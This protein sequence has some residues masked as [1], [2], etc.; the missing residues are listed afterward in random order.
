M[1][2]T[3]CAFVVGC[4]EKEQTI[5]SESIP[6]VTPSPDPNRMVPYY[7]K[8]EQFSGGKGTKEEPYLIENAG[9]LALLA[10]IFSEDGKD[11]YWDYK[12]AYFKQIDDIVV[13]DLTDIENWNTKAPAYNWLPIGSYNVFDGYYDGNGYQISGVYI[14]EVSSSLL[15]ASGLFGRISNASI[16]DVNLNNSYVYSNTG[17]G[18]IV[19]DAQNSTINNCIFEG[20]I[21]GMSCAGGIAGHFSGQAN[22]CSNLGCIVSMDKTISYVGGIFGKVSTGVNGT[23]IEECRNDGEII[24]VGYCSQG[25]IAGQLSVNKA[26]ELNDNKWNYYLANIIIQNCENNGSI[27]GVDSN[28][29]AST[30]GIVGHLYSTESADM[31]EGCTISN[32]SNKGIIKGTGYVGGILGSS[33]MFH[34]PLVLSDSINASHVYSANYAGGIMG[35][36]EANTEIKTI[37]YCTNNGEVESAAY[38]GGI[39]GAYFGFNLDVN[40]DGETYITKCQNLGN[41]K[42][43]DLGGI[44]GAGLDVMQT[45]YIDSCI[46]EGT[47]SGDINTRSGGI[48]GQDTLASLVKMDNCTFKLTNCVNVG[49][50]IQGN[51]KLSF[52]KNVKFLEINDET[53]EEKF[54]A[55]DSSVLWSSCIGGI[56][57]SVNQS[58]VENCV[59]IGML[60]ADSNVEFI[61][62]HADVKKVKKEGYIKQPLFAGG[63]C[64]QYLFMES[65]TLDSTGIYNCAYDKTA[66]IAYSNFGFWAG[67]NSV[68]NI[69]AM[70]NTSAKKHAEELMNWRK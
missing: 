55:D 3:I 14:Y 29:D 24:G 57:G 65:D 9:H 35:Y 67:E 33:S 36:C 28:K 56:V 43:K 12:G 22:N 37:S 39:L 10:Y 30:G 26:F 47:I 6:I 53:H 40:E 58:I 52:D 50:I 27:I 7:P 59:N 16:I 38:G 60:L 44:V 31:C 23:L 13:N 11:L 45:V 25:G 64:G 21:Y 2:A 46:N 42:G 54:E 19:G 5:S 48:L 51:G 63:I 69:S 62:D 41:I 17:A 70:D 66:P 49:D 8:T 32:C 15:D 4:G 68:Q 18:G 34:C 20:N 1:I 61:K